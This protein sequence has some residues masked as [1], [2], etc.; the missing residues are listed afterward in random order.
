MTIIYLVFMTVLQSD[1]LSLELLLISEALLTLLVD[2]Q[3]LI[4]HK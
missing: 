1:S 2:S 3:L 4:T